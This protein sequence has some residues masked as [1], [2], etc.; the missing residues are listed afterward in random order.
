MIYTNYNHVIT[1]QVVKMIMVALHTLYTT[2]LHNQVE[3]VT[4]M[5]QQKDDFATGNGVKGKMR[6]TLNQVLYDAATHSHFT[7][8]IFRYGQYTNELKTHI[9]GFEERNL[10]QINTFVIDIDTHEHSIETI[11]CTC[12]DESIGTPTFILKSPRGYQLYFVLTEPFFITNARNFLGLKVAKRISRNLKQSLHVIDADLYCN[13]F[14]FFRMP[15]TKNVVW[16]HLD[17][18]YSIQHFIEWS[19]TFDDG[20]DLF[21][22]QTEAKNPYHQE[23]IEALLKMR[24][25]KG[26]KDRIGRNNALFTLALVCYQAGLGEQVAQ[27]YLEQLNNQFSPSLR[28]NE[29]YTI[30]QSA[31]SGKYQGASYEYLVTLLKTYAPNEPIPT[32]SANW[33]KFKKTRAERVR[34]HFTEWE[35][36]LIHY[37]EQQPLSLSPFVWKTQKKLCEALNMPQSSLNT[38]LKQST[39]IMKVVKGKGRAA[40]TGWTT[41]IRFIQHLQ[42]V[43]SLKKMQYQQYVFTQL[44]SVTFLH[45]PCY[46][47]ILLELQHYNHP[48]KFYDSA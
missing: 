3:G 14:T 4:F 18:T 6:R 32:I 22:K 21:H 11:L 42:K 23:W 5:V 15:N 47:I 2:L 1:G 37:I 10:K 41:R 43:Q 34:S 25:V 17:Q 48:A 45:N 46:D 28:F 35:E 19:S 12:I 30:L 7:P 16:S 31:F 33:Y 38:L 9:K 36:D 13:D 8:N 39:H 44:R 27:D 40:V 20:E 29:L 24:N 26:K